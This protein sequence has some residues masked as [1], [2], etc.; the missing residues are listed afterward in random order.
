MKR[1]IIALLMA[2][3]CSTAILVSC[4]G[5]KKSCEHID[6]NTDGVCD[7]CKNA[8][9]YIVEQLP[10]EK[11]K[12]VAMVVNPIPTDVK[13]SEFISSEVPEY[14]VIKANAQKTTIDDILALRE[15]EELVNIDTR[16]YNNYQFVLLNYTTKIETVNTEIVPEQETVVK[17]VT[18]NFIKLYDLVKGEVV[19]TFKSGEAIK[20]LDLEAGNLTTWV[21]DVEK[22]ALYQDDM[23]VEFEAGY[24]LVQKNVNNRVLDQNDTYVK[25]TQITTYVYTY[26]WDLIAEKTE[27]VDVL[28]PTIQISTQ[29]RGDYYYITVD[30]TTYSVERD[31]NKLVT[32]EDAT[33]AAEY[34]LKRPTFDE[35]AGD[36]GFIFESEKIYVYDLTKWISCTNVI[37]YPSYW[38]EATPFV[39]AD[40]NI[41]VQYFKILPSD[42]INYDF[43]EGNTKIDACQVIINPVTG[44]QKEVEFGYLIADKLDN[45]GWTEKATNVF[46]IVPIV[47]KTIANEEIIVAVDNELNIQYAYLPTLTGQILDETELV[48]DGVF[49]TIIHYGGGI[50]Q[51][52]LM[53]ADGE[54][55]VVVP[56]NASFKFGLAKINNKLYKLDMETLV[57]DLADYS[58][59]ANNQA[60]M[61]LSK[62][63]DNPAYDAV[64][65]P[66]VP[67]TLTT[68]Y[69]FNGGDLV[70]IS[71]NI[72][73]IDSEYYVTSVEDNTD[74]ENVKTIYKLYNANNQFVA[75]FD[76]SVSEIAQV[77]E[78]VYRIRLTGGDYVVIR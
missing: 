8:V 68:N 42:T 12:E 1:K 59:K 26:N 34:H 24:I 64:E 49:G 51:A 76:E 40:G 45:E 14:Q 72:V 22:N 23:G 28:I 54:K 27:E 15:G 57:L 18:E 67:Q 48:A 31:S 2:T 25:S 73:K 56:T 41:L 78:G 63:V 33:K 53:N 35:I 58:I 6:A 77:S 60:Y 29:S 19:L 39:L 32:L 62:T 30:G 4:D 44:A 21:D 37:E 38:L 10:A 7:G 71:E 66:L 11:E 5:K 65:N 50:T 47:E 55:L 17:T 36:V 74:P 61:I 20:A 13:M 3:L 70:E 9:V 16:F 43:A 52:I 46:E 69:F 75:Q